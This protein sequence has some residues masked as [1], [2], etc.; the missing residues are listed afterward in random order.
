MG[1]LLVYL[2]RP[3]R[4]PVSD[5]HDITIVSVNSLPTIQILDCF[6]DQLMNV[7]LVYTSVYM[8]ELYLSSPPLLK[9]WPRCGEIYCR[10]ES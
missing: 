4:I 9:N 5:L 6:V 8:I 3:Y 10:R 1:C 7:F 2:G